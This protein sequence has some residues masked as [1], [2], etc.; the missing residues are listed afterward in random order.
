[1]TY[2]AYEDE[3]NPTMMA[4]IP[5][6]V[7]QTWTFDSSDSYQTAT[8]YLQIDHQ[9][10]LNEE[11]RYHHFVYKMISEGDIQDNSTI[12]LSFDPS[13]ERLRIHTLCLYR[14]GKKI[15]KLNEAKVRLI[16]KE[17][18]VER[19][20][21]EGILSALVFLDDVQEGD[22]LEYAYSIQGF[23]PIVKP[24]FTARYYFQYGE[25][26]ENYTLRLI[27]K[28]EQPLFIKYHVKDISPI[29]SPSL[30]GIREWIWQ[31]SHLEGLRIENNQP[32]WYQ[33]L[34]SIQFSTFT[35]WNEVAQW[36]IECFKLPDH[37]WENSP[38]EMQDLVSD[39]KRASE[40]KEKLALCAVRFVQDKIRYLGIGTGPY[41]C[42]P[43]D[44]FVVF[45]NRYGDCKDKTQL[46]R[47]FLALLDIESYPVLVNHSLGESLN[48]FL[49]SYSLFDHAILFIV[50]GE[51]EFWIDSTDLYQGGHLDDNR[52]SIYEC[53][54]VLKE[55]THGLQV[56]PSKDILP[57]E[58]EKTILITDEPEALLQ[59]K[60]LYKGGFANFIRGRLKEHGAA[61]IEDDGFSFH[62]QHFGRV[63][64]VEDCRIEDDRESNVLKKTVKYSIEGLI[65]K[66][67]ENKTREFEIAPYHICS[68]LYHSIDPMR[69]TPLVHVFPC[70]IIERYTFIR[71]DDEWGA[72]EEEKT[73][74]NKSFYLHSKASASGK[75]MTFEFEYKSLSDHI[76]PEELFNHKEALQQALKVVSYQCNW[77]QFNPSIRILQDENFDNLVQKCMTESAR[78]STKELKP[79]KPGWSTFQT[80][81]SLYFFIHGL[82]Y[83]GGLMTQ[84]NSVKPL[85]ISEESEWME[86][87][88][89]EELF[90]HFSADLLSDSYE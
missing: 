33:N 32:S 39:W 44:P 3:L 22:I 16:Q 59:A 24:H 19:H 46:L 74:Q 85:Q 23:N 57:V 83:L 61:N 66:G 41:A 47:T 80:L 87:R 89:D 67:A 72:Q 54:L 35:N 78:S 20:I 56:I 25:P 10:N 73:I 12:D 2:T 18:N 6:W 21:Y 1:M 14:N 29:T 42:Q 38:K 40:D 53:A 65:R 30:A 37:L 84:H 43:K 7:V 75:V 13:F 36:G 4:P 51:K 63:R 68:Y 55:E 45:S 71:T 26:V 17:K 31:L 34:P 15:D 86:D 69:S 50:I 48:H 5:D 76:P 81:A 64:L 90:Q 82:I 60:A 52:N 27:E 88:H 9:I 28:N 8:N 77:Q 62:A 58:Y 79:K 11:M 49:P 70:H